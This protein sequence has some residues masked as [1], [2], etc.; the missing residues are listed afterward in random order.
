VAV[1]PLIVARRDNERNLD[2]IETLQAVGENLVGAQRATALDV[3]G[4]DDEFEAGR[5]VVDRLGQRRPLGFAGGTVLLVADSGEGKS[6]RVRLIGLEQAGKNV[7]ISLS[8]KRA[9]RE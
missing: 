5:R 3:A 9:D 1:G 2:R 4:M 7:W 6:R 8:R